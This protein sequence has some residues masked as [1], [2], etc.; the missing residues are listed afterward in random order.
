MVGHNLLG[1]GEQLLLKPVLPLLLENARLLQ[2]LLLL[3]SFEHDLLL[4]CLPKELLL[5]L[6][7]SHLL[8]PQYLLL[9]F[10]ELLVFGLFN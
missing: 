5:F 4:L 6:E 8:L 7:Q 3:L 1:H 2:D 10:Q 9:V